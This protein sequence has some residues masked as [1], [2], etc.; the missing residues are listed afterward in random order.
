MQPLSNEDVDIPLQ[1]ISD[2]DNFPHELECN[3]ENV[4]ELLGSLDI[5]KSNGPDGISARM[6]KHTAASI[7]PSI[8]QLYNQ[9]LHSCRVPSEWKSSLVVPIPKGS[10]AGSPNNYLP[11]SLLVVLSKILEKHVHSIITQHLNLCHPI[12]NQ[13]WGFTAGRSTIG[14]LLSTVHD[15]FKLLE[16]G[17]DICAVFLDYRKAFDSVPHRTLIEKLE[18]IGVNPYIIA[19]LSDYLTSRKQRVVVDGSMSSP[20]DVFS[21]VPQG[22]ILGPLLFLIYI[23]GVT[24]VELSN[25]S[26][27]VL[28]ADDVLIYS[29]ISCHTDCQLLQ[30]DINTICAWS[31]EQHLTLNPQKC[32]FMTIS[33]KRKPT[34]TPFTFKLNNSP[35]EE[36]DQFKYLGVLFC[37]NLSWSPHIT[38]TCAKAKKILGL[39]YRRF[40]NHSSSECLKQLY[41]SLVRPHLDY[42][43]QVWDPY[44]QKDVQLLENM[45]KFALKLISHNWSTSYQTSYHCQIY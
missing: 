13:Q 23:D 26:R 16:E 9:L 4:C 10:D 3:E 36:V 35:M 38:S 21:G 2:P 15:W 42:A 40:Y 19:W 24:E 14:A 41:L 8:T 32:K 6:L 28:Y 29:P 17:K 39:L 7:S 12:S 27:L 11:I 33:R 30:H 5:N 37:H 22:S 20:T 34:T 18:G 25:N 44:L 45:Q 1:L 43:A 31:I